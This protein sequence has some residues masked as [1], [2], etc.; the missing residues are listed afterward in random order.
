MTKPEYTLRFLS[1]FEED[2]AEIV[3]YIH[4]RLKNPLA[5]RRFVDSV[6]KAIAER[7]PFAESFPPYQSSRE[8]RYPYYQ[9][10]VKNF[11][12]FYVVIGNVMEVRRILYSRS[13]W[14]DRI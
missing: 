4:Y 2:M 11:T 12:I 9:I 10:P 5:A 13:N 1:L 3:D 7:L 8:R 6:E 14:Q